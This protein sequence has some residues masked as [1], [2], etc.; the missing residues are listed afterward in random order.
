MS[1]PRETH[2]E[3]EQASPASRARPEHLIG[4]LKGLDQWINPD[5][6][7]EVAASL[8]SLTQVARSVYSG[9]LPPAVEFVKYEEVMPGAGDRIL[10]LAE[11]EQ[12]LRAKTI[13]MEGR[14]INAATLISLATIG[15]SAFAIG[16]GVVWPAVPLGLGGIITLFLREVLKLMRRNA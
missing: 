4:R 12:N 13:A 6:P 15:V 3:Q 14:R 10:K 2:G 11:G 1:E 16:Q 7:P 5:A 8:H 9:P